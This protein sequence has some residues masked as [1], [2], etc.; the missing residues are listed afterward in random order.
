MKLGRRAVLSGAAVGLASMAGCMD[1]ISGDTVEFTAS[2]ASVSDSGL[3]E[4][5]YNHANTEELTI[6]ETVEAA[7]VERRVIVGNWINTYQND[8]TVQG[9][10]QQAATFAVVSTP[11][12]EIAGQSLNPIGQLS[13]EE[14][15]S[16]FQSQLGDEYDGLDDVEQVDSRE[17]VVLGEEVSVSTFE[18][19]AEFEGEEVD[20][21]IHVTTVASGDDL[22][23]AV[24]AHPAALG[25]ERSNSYTLMQEVEH[26]G[27]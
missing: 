19:T 22:I 4:T 20:I 11:N 7:G 1:L 5:E 21:Y 25:Q 18:T 27:E 26:V 24:G 17:E 13:H 8:L 10:S 16:E 23:I 12:A 9:D 15:L 3:E 6:D 14:L 2:E